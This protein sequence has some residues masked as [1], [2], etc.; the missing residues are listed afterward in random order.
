MVTHLLEAKLP[1]LRPEGVS[2]AIDLDGQRA[3]EDLDVLVL[4]GMEVQRRLLAGEGEQSRVVV[5]EGHL[6]GKGATGMR[7]DGGRN[8]PFE[9][10]EGGAALAGQPTV[11]C[12]AMHCEALRGCEKGQGPGP[13]QG[14]G[15]RTYAITVVWPAVRVVGLTGAIIAKHAEGRSTSRRRWDEC[16]RTYPFS[17]APVVSP[18]GI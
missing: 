12:T 15:V 6:E 5:V 2:L 1:I 11:L 13:G 9:S 14:E 3:L 7:D 8:G 17:A 10:A 4:E 18:P 16:G